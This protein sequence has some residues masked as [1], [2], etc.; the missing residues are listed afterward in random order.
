MSMDYPPSKEAKPQMKKLSWEKISSILRFA[1]TARKEMVFPEGYDLWDLQED[2]LG[3]IIPEG[4]AHKLAV[5]SLIQPWKSSV[6]VADLLALSD[7]TSQVAADIGEQVSILR[8]RMGEPTD[9]LSKTLSPVYEELR[10]IQASA[11]AV[12]RIVRKLLASAPRLEIGDVER[13]WEK[14]VKAEWTMLDHE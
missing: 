4:K 7:A 5:L 2:F 8:H 10:S 13:G 1:D 12:N 6:P 3:V 11:N 14:G 9:H